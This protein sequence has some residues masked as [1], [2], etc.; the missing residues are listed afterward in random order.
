M[1]IKIK[2]EVGAYAPTRKHVGDAYDLYALEDTVLQ[3]HMTTK[4]RTGVHM[5]IPYGYFGD[6]RSRSSMYL[7]GLSCEG[8]ID[9]TY[10][11][12]IMALINNGNDTPDIVHRGERVAQIAFVKC[13]K[14]VR[15]KLVNE[16]K[17]T[18]RGAGGFGSTGK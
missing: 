12:E 7:A 8:T 1:R 10:T 4:V 11:G 9:P 14:T 16:L 13:A 17:K 6:M 15:F 18:T 5:A 2:L 3:P